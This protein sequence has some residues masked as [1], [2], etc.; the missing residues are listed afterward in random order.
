M[1]SVA[2]RLGAGAARLA[3]D[4]RAGPARPRARGRGAARLGA[5]ATALPLPLRRGE[6]RPAAGAPFAGGDGSF[7][8]GYVADSQANGF[9]TPVLLL[10]AAAVR[11]PAARR[12]TSGCRTTVNLASRA[13]MA[14][15]FDGPAGLLPA[16]GGDRR[17]PARAPRRARPLGLRPAQRGRATTRARSPRR[18]ARPGCPSWP[19]CP[20]PSPASRRRSSACATRYA[21]NVL[22]GYHVSVWG[23]GVRHLPQRPARRRGRRARRALGR[24]LPQPRRRASTCSSSSSPIATPAIASTSTAPAASGWWDGERLP[25]PPALPRRA[26]SSALDRP[27]VLW[28]IPLGN[29]RMRAM[30]NT[31]GHYQD[32]RVQTLLDPSL[33]RSWSATATRAS[34]ASCSATPLEGATC[35]CDAAERRC[36]QPGADQRQRP[37]RVAQRRRRRRLLQAG[38]RAVRRGRL[39]CRRGTVVVAPAPAAAAPAAR[40]TLGRARRSGAAAGSCASARG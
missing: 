19:A 2:R 32:N 17:R 15:Y 5:A 9:L 27:A 21:P 37:R 39:S 22:L 30:D 25:P 14:A 29:T 8:G 16:R 12:P 6:H 36:H 13:T 3:A 23:T 33:T 24:L 11:S 7:V 28:Q 20:T 10:P 40:F 18:S 26:S 4:R 1:R 38:G 35:A 34:S 31:R